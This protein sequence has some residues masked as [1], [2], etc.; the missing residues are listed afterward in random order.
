MERKDA[1][2][3]VGRIVRI[4]NVL[5]NPTGYRFILA[6]FDPSRRQFTTRNLHTSRESALSVEDL[7]RGMDEG[8]LRIERI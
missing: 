2:K 5:G 8:L 1:V 4:W 3:L 6:R 7:S